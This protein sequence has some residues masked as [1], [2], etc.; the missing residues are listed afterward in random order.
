M[1]DHLLGSWFGTL[2]G[3]GLI[4][5]VVPPAWAW[6]SAWPLWAK[7]FVVALVI[8]SVALAWRYS[9]LRRLDRL[10]V[11][12]NI[13]PAR[14]G[15]EHSGF[16]EH[17][18]VLWDVQ[19]PRSPYLGYGVDEEEYYTSLPDRLTVKS[20]PICPE[21]RVTLSQRRLFFSREFKWWC[22]A[23]RFR[24]TSGTSWSAAAKAAEDSCRNEMRAKLDEWRRLQS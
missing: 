15:Y 9:Y 23:C 13:A 21:C 17:G 14:Y 10:P 18:G 7:A 8:S 11:T 16:F 22:H 24:L 6:V 19:R 20:R 12:P 3:A 1:L 2:V 5:R 4:V